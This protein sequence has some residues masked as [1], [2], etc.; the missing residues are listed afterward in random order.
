MRIVIDLLGHH[1]RVDPAAVALALT[2]ARQKPHGGAGAHEL[3][4]AAPLH[5]PVALESLRLEPAL[6][7]ARVR[8]FDIPAGGRTRE[9]VRRHALGGLEPGVV[10]AIERG[11]R[12]AAAQ[13]GTPWHVL[14]TEPRGTDPATLWTALNATAAEKDAVPAPARRPRLAYVSPLPPERSG[15]AD[16]SAELVPELARFYELE[17]VV[18]Q[19]HVQD[20]RLEGL[21]LR[22]P[23]WLR[24]NAHEIDR[25]LYHFGN[26]HAHRHMFEL[27]REVPGVVVLHDFYF[28]GV[29]DNLEREG[30]LDKG[31]L[32]ALYESHGYSGLLDHLKGGRHPAIWKYP[33]NKGVLDNA[34]GVIVHSDFSKELAAHWYGPDAASGWRTIPL[35]RGRP[36]QSGTLE[37]RAAARARL[38]L[39]DGDYAV[40]TFGML[41]RTKRNAELLDAF[42]ASAL[43]QDP[44]CLLVFVGEND[45]GP[46]GAGLLERI[47]ASGAAARIRITGFADAATYADWLAAC[48]CAVQLRSSTRGETSASVLDCL[49]YGVPTIVNA[50]GSTASVPDALLLKLQD[51]FAN[52]ELS[53]ALERLRAD[54]ALR[55]DLGRRAREHMAREHAPDRVGQLVHEAIEQLAQ[56][57]RHACYASTVRAV[58]PLCPAAELQELAAAIAFNRP[59]PAQRQLLVDV[60][61]MVQ[62]D[63]KTGIQRVVRSIL[64]AMIADPPPGWRIEPVYSLGG[65][66][67][68]HYARRFAL[69]LVGEEELAMED[70]PAELRPGDI[71]F[72]LDLFTTGTTQNE[73][74]LLAMRDRGLDVVFVVFDVL[75]MLRPEVFPF[76]TEQYFGDFLRTVHRVSHGVLCIS[77]AVADELAGWIEGQGLKRRAPLKLGHFHLGADIDA[78]APSFG[79]PPDADQVLQ[80]LGERP[81]FLMVGTVE[82]RKGHAQAL[83]AFELLWQRGVDANLVVVGKQGWMVDKL[84]E[85]MASHPEKDKRLF[86]LAGISD[87]MLLKLYGRSSALLAPSEGEGFGLP[88]IEAAQH[89]IPILARSLPVFREVAGEH[90]YYFDG[91]APDDLAGAVTRWLALHA[92]GKAPPSTDMPWLTWDQSA[93]QVLDA[94]V[95]Q[96]WY[97][98]LPGKGEPTP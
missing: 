69:K 57:G 77:R 82:P 4:V 49:L 31:F 62:S 95:R 15:I 97:R 22:D 42:L 35:L 11:A 87:E 34:L 90:A 27:V 65:N 73:A 18:A 40:C 76:G 48:D 41:G 79:L 68:Y 50:H 53:A 54:A 33:L 78:S 66:R 43:A 98:I 81:S 36:A 38:G 70:A 17:L 6:G 96:Q 20:P 39:D 5:D 55:A 44:D 59:P 85:R 58:A 25:V 84:A 71:F 61:A 21:P 75:P 72:G 9:L 67:P 2:L 86:W 26:S 19:E 93:R 91:L 83:A 89:H 45:P 13:P 52:Y 60:S 92:D 8:A 47:A 51:E 30:Y 37:A 14:H 24:A 23:D 94:L 63:L 16:Y 29:L 32:H 56:R 3:W 64:L 28:S 10:L 12:P 88:L 7:A 1:G 74:Q 80:A 46:Y